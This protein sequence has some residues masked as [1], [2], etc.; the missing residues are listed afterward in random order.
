LVLQRQP[1]PARVVE[2]RCGQAGGDARLV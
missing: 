2:L 1:T